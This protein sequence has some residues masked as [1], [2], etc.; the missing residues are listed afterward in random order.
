[1]IP[2]LECL[3]EKLKRE[4]ITQREIAD[5]SS[6]WPKAKQMVEGRAQG[7]ALQ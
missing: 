6:Q 5:F 7:M 2:L 1:M 3:L 4:G